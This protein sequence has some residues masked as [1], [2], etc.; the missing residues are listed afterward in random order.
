MA[1]NLSDARSNLIVCA[2]LHSDSLIRD[3]DQG[4]Q[5]V[6]SSP[7]AV[8]ERFTLRHFKLQGAF[9]H[10]IET[11]NPQVDCL[12]FENTPDL[13]DLLKYLQELSILI[14]AVI[15]ENESQSDVTES[16]HTPLA[17]ADEPIAWPNF[18]KLYHF[19]TLCISST[20]LEQI[21]HVIDE[22]IDKF[23]RLSAEG[24]LLQPD[25]VQNPIAAL[26]AHSSLVQQQKR[27]SEKLK[28]RLGYLGV[29]YKRNPAHFLRHMTQRE[30]QEFIDQLKTDYRQII[31]SYF[32]SQDN[33]NQ[34]IDTFVNLAFFAD[35]P[36]AQIVE[37]HM[38]LMDEFA[39]QLK[40]EGRSDEVL[41]D[42]RLTLIDTIAHLCEMYRR[43][44]PRES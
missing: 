33:L 31:L 30:R 38:E 32:S 19:A 14:P 23:L 1:S 17:H 5:Q 11:A 20:Q 18:Q 8:P 9:F 10:F 36:V 4:L 35:V 6:S 42:Y 43:S 41:L 29:Y 12:L 34:K 27:L 24:Q 13:P 39:K 37:I 2:L 22:A 7:N 44:I 15:I 28:E 26:A 40:L 21:T 3:L 25:A 16:G